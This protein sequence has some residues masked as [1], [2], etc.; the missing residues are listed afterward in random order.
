MISMLFEILMSKLS[1]LKSKAKPVFNVLLAAAFLVA[2]FLWGRASV[3]TH[4]K[5]LAV[6]RVQLAADEKV[7]SDTKQL[8]IDTAKARASEQTQ[9]ISLI[10]SAQTAKEAA[11]AA[12]QALDSY[13]YSDV[14]YE[15]LRSHPPTTPDTSTVAASPGLD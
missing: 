2:V 4:T 12:P 7:I 14:V 6:A 15:F 13:R 5:E 10:K 3:D 1:G 8:A 11:Y 9:L